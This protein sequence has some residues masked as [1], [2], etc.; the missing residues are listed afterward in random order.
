MP[1]AGANPVGR[2][3]CVHNLGHKVVQIAG[4][5]AVPGQGALVRGRPSD[6]HVSFTLVAQRPASWWSQ[7]SGVLAR[8]GL[9]RAGA[10][11]RTTGVIVVVL[12]VGSLLAVLS[13]VWRWVF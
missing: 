10:G 2:V 11:G 5:G 1:P 4:E 7:A 12:L 6:F 13:I 3:V 9:G 8:V